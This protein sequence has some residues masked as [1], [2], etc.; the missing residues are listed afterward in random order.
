MSLKLY[1]NYLSCGGF[2]FFFLFLHH[3]FKELLCAFSNA[4]TVKILS[5]QVDLKGL[6][7]KIQAQVDW[8]LTFIFM[9]LTLKVKRSTI[10]ITVSALYFQGRKIFFLKDEL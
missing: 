3:C 8:I 1:A 9:F 7:S 5:L 2:E 6:S 4:L 10:C